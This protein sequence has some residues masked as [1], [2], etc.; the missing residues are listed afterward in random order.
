[1]YT[2]FIYFLFILFFSNNIQADEF[3]IKINYGTVSHASVATSGL[4]TVK[5][6][7]DDLGYKVS[8]AKIINE[9]SGVEIIYYDL[10]DSS[11]QGNK[12]DLFTHDGAKYQFKKS[13]TISR[14]TSGFGIGG[15]LS[16]P[17]QILY[18]KGYIKLGFHHW[19]HSGTTDLLVG[20][21]DTFKPHYYNTGYDLY[22]SLGLDFEFIDDLQINIEYSYFSFNDSTFGQIVGTP[23]NLLSVGI[24]YSF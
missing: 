2:K 13:G 7:N 19:D 1:M 21:F 20:S 23:S 4:S 9:Y 24:G 16:S 17:E 18:S 14:N 3:N 5:F 15:I 8:L 11:I 22:S 10:G 12:D 6:D